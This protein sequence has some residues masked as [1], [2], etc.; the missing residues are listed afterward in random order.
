[1]NW[2][3]GVGSGLGD[4]FKTRDRARQAFDYPAVS[5]ANWLPTRPIAKDHRHRI[6]QVTQHLVR[7]ERAPASL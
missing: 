4:R 2:L 7:R 1:V 3:E 5:R 6:T